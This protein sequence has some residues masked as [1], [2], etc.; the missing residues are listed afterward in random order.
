MNSVRGSYAPKGGSKRKIAVFRAL[1]SE[2]V[3]YKV[4]LCEN[5]QRRVVVNA[6]MVG[7]R[8]SLLPQILSEIVPLPSKTLNLIDFRS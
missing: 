5:L 4:S 1:F 3:C 2:K 6:K 8:R 7:S